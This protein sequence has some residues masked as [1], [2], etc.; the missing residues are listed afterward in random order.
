MSHFT[1]Y[2]LTLKRLD[3]KCTPQVQTLQTEM[4]TSKPN[5]QKT[6]AGEMKVTVS[7]QQDWET[8]RGGATAVILLSTGSGN[9]S[10]NTIEFI[11]ESM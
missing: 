5:N 8:E 11:S 2:R 6:Q 7:E 1:G 10:G 4:E 9:S 3:N